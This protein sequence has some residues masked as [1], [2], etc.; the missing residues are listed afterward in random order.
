[1]KNGFWDRMLIYL[2]VLLTLLIV[3]AIGL[4]A[5]GFDLIGNF[6]AN[7]SAGV[8]GIFWRLILL[9]VCVLILLLGVFAAVVITPSRVRKRN[10]ITLNADNGGQ[11]RIALP[12]LRQMTTQAI[13]GMVGL[14]DVEINVAES[15]D[16]AIAVSVAMDVEGGVHVPTVTMSMQ[17]AIRETIEKNCGVN[18]RSV[19]VDVRAVLPD[20]EQMR[21]ED[22]AAA[23]Q[24]SKLQTEADI[25]DVVE[26]EPAENADGEISAGEAYDTED[27]EPAQAEETAD[28]GSTL[29][30]E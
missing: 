15:G 5:F 30:D 9:G 19:T 16:D 13:A 6:I 7:L 12:A 21:A 22:N 20:I 24:N 8:P 29:T 3:A 1:M 17:S 26:S 2:Y 14:R 11:V 28:E 27:A 23:E 25:A 18:V 10:F 4:R